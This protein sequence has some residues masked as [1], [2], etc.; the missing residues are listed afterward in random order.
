M[1][2]R[3]IV[4]QALAL[5]FSGKI[6][7]AIQLLE[8]QPDGELV[9][10]YHRVKLLIS[11]IFLNNEDID[12]ILPLIGA[13]LRVAKDKQ[14]DDF[15]DQLG[16]ALYYQEMP[17]LQSDFSRSKAL[18][19]RVKK[20]RE[21]RADKHGLVDSCFHLG[22]VAQYAGDEKS[23]DRYF[24]SSAALSSELELKL[25]RSYAVRHLGILAINSKEFGKGLDHL[26]ESLALREEIGF[27][28]YMPFSLI[29]VA[30]CHAES[31][32]I[33]EAYA[34]YFKA[35]QA[36]NDIENTRAI[37]LASINLGIISKQQNNI[38]QAKLYLQE[39]RDRAIEFGHQQAIRLAE[40][41]LSSL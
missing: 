9:F 12:G 23:A 18:F 35:L 27:K 34:Y 10:L 29:S 11:N 5:Y 31:G 26:L 32:A 13:A 25:E 7:S 14:R 4:D 37:M 36:G 30:D 19:E 21:D 24:S 38:E 15:E 40:E 3:E 2:S 28:I 20:S 6:G 17:N 41:S 1:N 33:D 22:L 16:L 8:A 39:G